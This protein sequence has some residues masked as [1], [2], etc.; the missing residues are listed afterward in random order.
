VLWQQH[1]NPL[2]SWR[3]K[4]FCE[5]IPDDFFEHSVEVRIHAHPHSNLPALAATS[6]PQHDRP[7]YARCSRVITPR[8]WNV[9]PLDTTSSRPHPHVEGYSL[10]QMHRRK[11]RQCAQRDSAATASHGV[12]GVFAKVK[13]RGDN[14]RG[15]CGVGWAVFW[16]WCWSYY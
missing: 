10:H 6:S 5:W 15:C 14:L 1:W 13:D 11:A 3:D 2:R 12:N 7:H 9:A 4:R 16:C 8:I